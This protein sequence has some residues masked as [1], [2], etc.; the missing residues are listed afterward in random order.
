[1]RIFGLILL[2]VGIVVLLFGLNSTQVVTEKVVEGVTG[3]F[4][5]ATML[6]II[7]GIA[8]IVAGGALAYFDR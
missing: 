4:T 6:Y 1:M 3:R 7:G 5:S 2:V 8:L